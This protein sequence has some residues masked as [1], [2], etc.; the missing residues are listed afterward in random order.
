MVDP[1]PNAQVPRPKRQGRRP[2]YHRCYASRVS[3]YSADGSIP[4]PQ[5]QSKQKQPQPPTLKVTF[6][7]L[8]SGSVKEI[9]ENIRETIIKANL[10]LSTK[11]VLEEGSIQKLIRT[12]ELVK[13]EAEKIQRALAR[14]S[15]T[16]GITSMENDHEITLPKVPFKEERISSSDTS[17]KTVTTESGDQL[18]H[19]LSARILYVVPSHLSKRRG[20]KLGCAYVILQAPLTQK[21]NTTTDG[22]VPLKAAENAKG[23]AILRLRLALALESL[24]KVG[25][26]EASLSSKAWNDLEVRRG[27]REGTISTT[28]DYKRFM[29]QEEARLMNL[30]SRSKPA[31]GGGVLSSLS[32]EQDK[33][34][35]AEIVLHLRAK[36]TEQ[37]NKQNL[38][39][40]AK[41]EPIIPS[42]GNSRGKVDTTI[43]SNNN[44]SKNNTSSKDG[45]NNFKNNRDQKPRNQQKQRPKKKTGVPTQGQK[46]AEK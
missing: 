34:P 3:K 17:T 38:R 31:P 18:A 36:R 5:P 4:Q 28:A 8:K 6:R 20:I 22:A 23:T 12:E 45:P 15:A 35:L 46:Q 41:K 29:E 16:D 7:G 10:T 26:V 44:K 43:K 11:V 42:S 2:R 1:P 32:T 13:E 25:N 40:K 39:K 30:R 19:V 21:E 24:T 14:P 37:K 33:Q 9:C 27:T